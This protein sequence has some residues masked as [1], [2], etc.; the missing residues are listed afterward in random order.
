MSHFKIP[1]YLIQKIHSK[2]SSFFGGKREDERKI[3]WMSWKKLCGNKTSG[4]LG[5][6]NLSIFN[7]AL[8]AKLAWK[9]LRDGDSLWGKSTK[10]R[11]FPHTDFLSVPIGS[12]P[13][14]G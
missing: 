10:A 13:S 5:F 8:L 11:Y 6:Q 14:W 12:N 7:L 2:C 4:G 9:L 3:T 1:S